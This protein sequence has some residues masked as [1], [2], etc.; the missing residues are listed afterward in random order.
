MSVPGAS[1]AEAPHHNSR[2]IV[3]AGVL[4]APFGSGALAHD[5]LTG[6]AHVLDPVAAWVV[7]RA[8]D[9][10][11]FGVLV[12][13]AT[14][15]AAGTRADVE[16]GLAAGVAE[17]RRLGLLD[18][19]D[20]YQAPTPMRGSDRRAGDASLGG[21]HAVLDHGI[22]FRG[23]DTDLLAEIDRFLGTVLDDREATLVFDVEPV[24]DEV[25]LTT[26]DEWRFP[27]RAGFWAQLPGVV[28]EYAARSHGHP[29]LHAG[30]V[31]TP[32]GRLLLV[33]GRVDAGKSTVV[34]ALVRAGCEYLGD[35]SIGIR[36]GTL[37]AVAYAKP[38][39]L[40]A[41]SREL[42]SLPPSDAPHLAVEE[43]RAD[44]VRLV[45]DVGTVDHIVL[46]EYVGPRPTDPEAT[47]AEP[48]VTRLDPVGA[49]RALLA[50]TL[51]LA[52]SG[53]VGLETLCALA[54]SVPVTRVAHTDS[55]AVADAIV[56]GEI[57]PLD[58]AESLNPAAGVATSTAP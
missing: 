21:V 1:S 26:A 53:Q 33:P 29:V 5:A 3:S 34:A 19:A 44:V 7:A 49:V 50:N 32:D 30:A 38:F 14:Q 35:E 20:G 27:S 9:A 36:P 18:R 58:G 40:D 43:L 16:A 17:L 28:N 4:L 46:P 56:R 13:E 52:R 22:A 51:N 55:L 41:T 8:D 15:V 11:A 24:G 25:L 47:L 23:P 39:T 57:A 37:E 42:L 31:R 10:V 48:V 12:D 2:V 54:E 45:G 6:T